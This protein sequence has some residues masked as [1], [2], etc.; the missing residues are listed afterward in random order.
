MKDREKRRLRRTAHDVRSALE[1]RGFEPLPDDRNAELTVDQL[2]E[3]LYEGTGHLANLAETLAR[4]HGKAQALTFFQMMG[5]C[6]QAFWK[7]IA[8]QLIDHSK[9]WEA[10]EGSACILS[11]RETKRLREKYGV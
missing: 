5:P 2:A 1:E 7:D 4:Q 3:A 11:K 9:E 8:Q 6:V 10:N